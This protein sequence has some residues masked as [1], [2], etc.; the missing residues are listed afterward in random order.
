[1]F[2]FWPR[3][4]AFTHLK[5]NRVGEKKKTLDGS[6]KV[7]LFYTYTFTE[8]YMYIYIKRFTYISLIFFFFADKT[9]AHLQFKR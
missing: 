8:I 2:F 9:F 4:I 7:S 5:R 1:V 3:K 6:Q